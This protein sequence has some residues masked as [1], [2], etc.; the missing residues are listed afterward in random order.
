MAL[1]GAPLAHEDHAVWACYAALWTMQA[2]DLI[3][4]T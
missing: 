2:G 3:L 4:E 1:F